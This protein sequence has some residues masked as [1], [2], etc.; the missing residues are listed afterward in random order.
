MEKVHRPGLTE[1]SPGN[2]AQQFEEDFSILIPQGL[3]PKPDLGDT[4][5]L[6]NFLIALEWPP[7]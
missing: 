5:D 6:S 7:W 3:S 2:S 4:F 1:A